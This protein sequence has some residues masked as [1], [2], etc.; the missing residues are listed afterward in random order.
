[1]EVTM[2]DTLEYLG[3]TKFL[4]KAE[5]F[6]R[7]LHIWGYYSYDGKLSAIRFGPSTDLLCAHKDVHRRDC[8][9]PLWRHLWDT[10]EER[11]HQYLIFDADE[12]YEVIETFDDRVPQLFGGR[13]DF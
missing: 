4:D 3:E 7:K 6:L 8:T 2:S 13:N 10:A 5:N 11:L 1:M 9:T 12:E